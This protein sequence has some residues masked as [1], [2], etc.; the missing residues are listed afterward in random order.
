MPF[1]FNPEKIN[2]FHESIKDDNFNRY[3]SWRYCFE[4]FDD[5]NL[6]DDVLALNLAFYLTSWGMYRGSSGL[7]QKDYKVH[8]EAVK[9]IRNHYDLRCSLNNDVNINMLSNILSIISKL[10]IYYT[11]IDYFNSDN[12]VKKLLQQTRLFLK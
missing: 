11:S 4:A 3:N 10:K 7:L 12:I 6:D 5:I 2:N 1:V 8:I 9:L